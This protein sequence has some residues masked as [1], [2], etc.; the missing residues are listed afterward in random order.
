MMKDHGKAGHDDSDKGDGHHAKGD[1]H[2]HAE[3]TKDH[4]HGKGAGMM[5]STRSGR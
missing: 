3:G 1:D 5:G 4:T 2:G